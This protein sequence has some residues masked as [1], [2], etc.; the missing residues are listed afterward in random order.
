MAGTSAAGTV[1]TSTAQN[2]NV[3]SPEIVGQVGVVA[4]EPDT[5]VEPTGVVGTGQIGFALVW[6]LIDD[7]QTPNWGN[8]TDTQTPSWSEVSDSQTPDWEEV[9]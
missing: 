8:I 1:T 4:V 6:S 9:A 5:N 2:I 7:A 3:T